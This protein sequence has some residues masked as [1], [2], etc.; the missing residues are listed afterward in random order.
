MTMARTQT[1]F[2]SRVLRVGWL[3]AAPL[4]T[5]AL[6]L[7]ACGSNPKIPGGSSVGKGS[8]P[9]VPKAGTPGGAAG[10]PGSSASGPGTSASGPGAP[11]VTPTPPAYTPSAPQPT[12]DAAAGLLVH[13]WAVNDR[14]GA[15]TVA[16]P[17][18]I[19]SLLNGPFPGPSD[20]QSRGCTDTN[21]PPVVCTYGPTAN[22]NPNLALY[23]I[24]VANNG[25]GWYVISVQ[26]ET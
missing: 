6:T 16:T 7:S 26:V 20:V 5:A 15:A 22:A 4:M 25:K 2:G 21:F 9:A 12:P 1:P 10:S 14:A 24:T 13:F 11:V 19:G 8:T 3:V 17:A 23:Q 18:A